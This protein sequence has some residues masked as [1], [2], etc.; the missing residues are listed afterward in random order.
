MSAL[1]AKE[2]RLSQ[3]LEEQEVLLRWPGCDLMALVA[4]MSP[5]QLQEVSKALGETLTSA[6]LRPSGGTGDFLSFQL[7]LFLLVIEVTLL[8]LVHGS[9]SG[10]LFAEWKGWRHF[11]VRLPS[12]SAMSLGVIW[13][14]IYLTPNC[15]QCPLSK[16]QFPPFPGAG[17]SLP[18]S[19]PPSFIWDSIR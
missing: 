18:P 13:Y 16:K 8:S 7:Y 9:F 11:D 2:K 12:G 6:N 4:Q 17:S 14:S 10:S 19:L 15:L 1:E 3:E 5:G